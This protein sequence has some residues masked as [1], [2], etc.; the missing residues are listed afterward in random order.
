[1]HISVIICTYN[2]A[3]I[4]RETLESFLSVQLPSDATTELLIVDNNSKDDTAAVAEEFRQRAPALIRYVHEPTPGL[5]YARNCGIRATTADLVAFVDDDVYFEPTWLVEM[6]KLFRE[7]PEAMCAGGRSI[8]LFEAGRPEWVSDNLLT[9]YGSTN[10]G[11]A[12]KRM[13]YPEHPFGLNMMF[14][15]RVF[16]TVGLFDPSLGR[17][18]TSL[19]SNEETE[20]FYRIHNAELPVLYTPHAVLHHRIAPERTQK[21]WVLKRYYWQGVSDVA[22]R[23]IIE[24]P[25]RIQ[26]AREAQR[27]LTRLL[28][29]VRTSLRSWVLRDVDAGTRF[30]RQVQ[31]RYCVGALVYTFREMFR[32]QPPDGERL[33]SAQGAPG[34]GSSNRGQH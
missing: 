28:S 3:R 10:S 25:G 4:F 33:L 29:L 7:H 17:I 22:F 19:L 31:R 23:R 27:T 32:P 2:R 13:V 34:D 26:L 6:L 15:R 8:P 20:L 18:G 1:M 9:L 11:D 5:S 14:R 16:D 12:V 24:R 30:H 21:Q